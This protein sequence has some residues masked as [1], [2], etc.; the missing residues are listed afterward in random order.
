MPSAN[1]TKSDQRA[2]LV[3]ACSGRGAAGGPPEGQDHAALAPLHLEEAR[4]G[5]AEREIVG[6]GGV[7][8]ADQRLGD[9]LERLAAQPPP[10]ERAEALV[11]ATPPRG[12]TRSQRHPELA[13][14]REERRREER[15]EARG[16]EELE[17]VRQRVEPSAK[18]HEDAAEA[19][20]GADQPVFHAEPAAERE[21]PRLLGEE[22]VG[23]AL[24]EEAVAALGLD[25]AAEAVRLL[26]AGSARA[27]DRARAASST[28]RWAAASPVSPPPTTMSFT[29]PARAAPGRPASR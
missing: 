9:A 20:V 19:V 21:R 23:A 24:D 10:H 16:R 5:G 27:A 3:P 4:H 13:R 7:D 8:A 26:R 2:P 6:I 17:A 14:P 15:P 25:G 11:G 12:S 1:V 28:A 29:P 18:R 22:R